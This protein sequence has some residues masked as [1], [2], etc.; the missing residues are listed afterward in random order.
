[1]S[2][3]YG[4]LYYRMDNWYRMMAML[5]GYER[6]KKNLEHMLSLNLREQVNVTDRRINLLQAEVDELRGAVEQAEKGRKGAETELHEASERS[7]LLHGQ[8]T[9]LANQKRKMEQELLQVANEV[10]EDEYCFF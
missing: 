5:P 9:L 6:N 4:R 10:E 8:N 3:V 7:N 1:M 2:L